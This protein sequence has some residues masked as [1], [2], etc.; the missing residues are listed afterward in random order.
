[1][2][3]SSSTWRYVII[4]DGIKSRNCSGWMTACTGD[5]WRPSI[6]ETSSSLLSVAA[7]SYCWSSKHVDERRRYE[8]LLLLHS[9]SL[10]ASQRVSTT[11]RS[12]RYSKNGKMVFVLS[13]WSCLEVFHFAFAQFWVPRVVAALWSPGRQKELVT[14]I[15]A[16]VFQSRWP[17]TTTNDQKRPLIVVH[18]FV[19]DPT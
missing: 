3:L 1:M 10:R 19:P 9:P 12:R 15:V 18:K 6:V 8:A 16:R 7:S 14:I 4:N 17:K 2:M 13:K 11:K 5:G